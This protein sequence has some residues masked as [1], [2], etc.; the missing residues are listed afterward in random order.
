MKPDLM[1]KIS[2]VGLIAD[3]VGSGLLL[4]LNDKYHALLLLAAGVAWI[5][6]ILILTKIKEREEKT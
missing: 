1:I 3:V 4:Y 5:F 6:S 2:Y